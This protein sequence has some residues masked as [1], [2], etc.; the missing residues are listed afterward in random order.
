MCLFACLLVAQERWQKVRKSPMFPGWYGVSCSLFQPTRHLGLC[1]SFLLNCWDDLLLL[2]NPGRNQT[3]NWAFL[4]LQP[5]V[6]TLWGCCIYSHNGLWRGLWTELLRRHTLARSQMVAHL[7]KEKMGSENLKVR[8]HT[9]GAGRA[10]HTRPRA[11]LPALHSRRRCG[12]SGQRT[13]APVREIRVQ[14]LSQEDPT[15]CG[16]TGRV[17]HHYWA[18]GPQ[19]G[20]RNQQAQVRPLLTARCAGT[21]VPQEKPPWRGA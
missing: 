4:K 5:Q 19:P 15:C 12:R 3:I 2:G 17:R 8:S 18:C 20:V 11:R 10:K 21:R 14:S 16:A 6:E 7:G 13:H 9:R 1:F